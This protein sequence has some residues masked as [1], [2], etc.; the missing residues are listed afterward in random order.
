MSFNSSGPMNFS[1][2]VKLELNVFRTMNVK[3]ILPVFLL[4]SASLTI[5][6]Q[7]IKT[8]WK[9]DFEYGG[10]P[11]P[12]SDTVNYRTKTRPPCSSTSTCTNSFGKDWGITKKL[13]YNGNYADSA[14]VNHGDTLWF[15]T[16]AFSTVGDTFVT[17]EFRHICKVSLF[18]AGK[19]EVS[20]DS[21][22][23]WKVLGATQYINTKG[24][25][26]PL[27]NSP[28]GYGYFSELSYSHL[29]NKWKSPYDSVPKNSW[30]EY[31]YFNAS[32]FLGGIKSSNKCMVRWA[33]VDGPGATT[34]GPEGR[35]GWIIDSIRVKSAPCENIKP[36]GEYVQPQIYH[37]S[38]LY[39][40]GPFNIF[41]KMYDDPVAHS[42]Y[43]EAWL[44]YTVNGGP[45]DSIKYLTTPTT[46]ADSIYKAIIP[47]VYNGVDSFKG[48]DTICYWTV[49]TDLSVPCRNQYSIPNDPTRTCNTFYLTNGRQL[50]YCDN[51]DSAL[52]ANFWDT[53]MVK[54]FIGWELGNPSPGNGY[55][56]HSGT[57]AWETVLANPGLYQNQDL[58]YVNSPIFDFSTAI[59]PRISFWHYHD[60]PTNTSDADRYRL[61][62]S[63]NGN[64]W[65]WLGGAFDANG[66]LLNA[67]NCPS[68]WY[69]QTN[70]WS[71]QFN[72]G[73][74]REAFYQLP[75]SFTAQ[76]QVQFRFA[77]TADNNSLRGKGAAIDDWC[78]YNPPHRDASVVEIVRPAADYIKRFGEKDS[79][80]IKVRNIGIDTLYS[81]PLCYEIR[82]TS[83]AVGTPIC[84]T[85]TYPHRSYNL[86]LPPLAIDSFFFYNIAKA[87]TIPSGLY[88]IVAYPNLSGDADHTNDTARTNGHFGFRVDTISHFT[89][90]DVLPPKWATTLIDPGSC[91]NPPPPRP[92][93]WQLGS[94]NFGITNSTYSPPLAWDINLTKKYGVE[95]FEVLYT[96]FFDFSNSDSAFLSFWHNWNTVLATDGYYID[97]SFNRFT[98]FARLTAASQ[99]IG[100]KINWIELYQPLAGS[101]GRGWNGLSKGWEYS[102][103][104]LNN[105]PFRGKTEVQFRFV[106]RST[107]TTAGLD[108]VSIDDF[109]IVNPDSFDVEMFDIVLPVRGCV[110]D[111][112]EPVD[113]VVKNVGKSNISNI[114]VFYQYRFDPTC[115]GTYGGWSTPRGDT[116]TATINPA[117]TYTYRFKDSVNMSVFGC[118]EFRV[119]AR[120]PK[121]KKFE[122][123]SLDEHVAENVRGCEIELKITT[124]GTTPNGEIIFQDSV[125]LDTLWMQPLS[126][127][128]ANA[129]QWSADICLKEKGTYKFSITST[130]STMITW[131]RLR[132]PFWDTTVLMGIDPV[133]KYFYFT[134]PPLLSASAGRID[135]Y[136]PSNLPIPQTYEFDVYTTNR[137]SVKL[138]YVWLT[139]EVIQKKPIQKNG[140]LILRFT[141]SLY[142]TYPGDPILYTRVNNL[143]TIWRAEPGEYQ[144]CS[145]TFD[146]NGNADSA[147]YDD[148]VCTMFVVLDT[149]S[150]IP[151]CNNFDNDSVN[152]WGSMSKTIFDTAST[153]E[154]GIPAQTSL[155]SARSGTKAWTVLLKKNYP[156]LDS[157]AL[158]SPEFRMDTS[159]CY[160]MNFFHKWKTEYAF[161]GGTVEFTSDSGK[162][163]AI[164]GGPLNTVD[165]AYPWSTKN[166]YNT[167][168]VT[169]LAGAPHPPGWTASKTAQW[170]ESFRDFKLPHKGQNPM[171]VV[172]RFRFGSDASVEN[173]G[174]V[175]DDFCLEPTGL[176]NYRSCADGIQNGDEEGID[177]G[178]DTAGCP[179]CES[180]VDGVLNQNESKVDCGGVCPPCPSCVDAVKNGQETAPDCG[181]PECPACPSCTDGI[182]TNNWIG[183]PPWTRKWEDGIDCGGP[184]PNPCWLGVDEVDPGKLFLGQTIPNP[185]TE[186]TIITYQLPEAGTCVMTVRSTLGQEMARIEPGNQAAGIH[187]VEI[188][189]SAWAQGVYYYSIDFNGEKLV[190]KMV[191]EN[192]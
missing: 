167:P 114:P 162:T 90:F 179:P 180:C 148:T 80:W 69:D 192:K 178:G 108:G 142:F 96:N 172:F 131:W 13:H 44:F 57:K 36:Y 5:D 182:L 15:R 120:H 111:V 78:I 107:L 71:G 42:G 104:P 19:V 56:A 139:T 176:C 10:S 61:E 49:I 26:G 118:Y 62:Y 72:N 46:S 143:D 113:I 37:G 190:S 86:G 119:W 158:Y 123:D 53:T 29:N 30:W 125:T 22:L 66:K 83:G 191:V 63:I 43:K 115:T 64:P 98:T 151:Y 74:W 99:P 51:F 93:L 92:T 88:K 160:N 103:I 170:M 154:H 100:K 101:F 79:V 174:W 168:Y 122:N 138:S 124:G 116:I 75:A 39:S 105:N 2:F 127:L 31:E 189:V 48:G 1:M 153:F 68:T 129:I 73:T 14:Q 126:V 156:Y 184:C 20:N 38:L 112:A 152:P 134:C 128:G 3:A 149:V 32:Q 17:I 50:P 147:T 82:D 23:T 175:I 91:G 12:C 164:L 65:T 169:G 7:V 4:L 59:T 150:Q 121:D 11:E 183:G 140:N 135:I 18:D 76:N 70:G 54:G 163:W 133:A 67:P 84:T 28:L 181:G 47:K 173:E 9:S 145:W 60:M 110:L 21:G 16:C 185:A 187:K 58:Y 146:P 130:D 144:I 155:N 102:Q 132:D 117:L 165:T 157:S 77:F 45:A 25:S 171:K 55:N 106:F 40:M 87:Y 6:A 81:I 35:Y 97:Y 177:C 166:W 41:A 52:T 33:T 27:W 109:R 188:D 136:G 24:L 186:K 141:D 34:Q 159:I 8:V 137:G 94:P 89:N 95:A 161:D 85:M